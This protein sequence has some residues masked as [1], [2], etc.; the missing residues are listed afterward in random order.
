MIF[1]DNDIV[2]FTSLVE[3]LSIDN[4]TCIFRCSYLNI[5]VNCFKTTFIYLLIYL[6]P[7]EGYNNIRFSNCKHDCAAAF[8]LPK[9]VIFNVSGEA[10]VDSPDMTYVEL[11]NELNISIFLSYTLLIIHVIVRLSECMP[12]FFNY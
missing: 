12:S 11:A 1:N 8:S 3:K 4:V 6:M 9:I 7:N 2:D 5:F 10:I